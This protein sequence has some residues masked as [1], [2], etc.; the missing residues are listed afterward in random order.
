MS[1][2]WFSPGGVQL[3]PG[4]YVST[5]PLSCW[6][7]GLR[8]SDVGLIG[9]RGNVLQG[10]AAPSQGETARVFYECLRCKHRHFCSS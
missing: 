3:R 6:E 4:A 7:C 5:V 9:I 8:L 10:W 1:W 2:S